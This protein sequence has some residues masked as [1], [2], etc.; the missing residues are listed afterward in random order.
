MLF[1][2]DAWEPV[3]WWV[4][5]LGAVLGLSLHLGNQAPDVLE[6]R[7]AGVRGVAQR[8]GARRATGLA[9]GLFGGV[10][11]TAVVLL[12]MRSPVHALF[13]A[14]DGASVALLAPRAP[15]FFGRDGL[16]GLLAAA[17]AVLAVIFLLA[18]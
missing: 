17:S 13:A 3:L 14:V 9:I 12:L 10:C 16:F 5:P 4:F 15:V 8:I 7:R 1:R 2:S 18:V 11:S 6:D